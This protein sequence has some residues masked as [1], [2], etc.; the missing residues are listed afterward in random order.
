MDAAHLSRR[1]V[2]AIS[3]GEDLPEP[4]GEYLADNQWVFTQ[5]LPGREASLGRWV[6]GKAWAARSRHAG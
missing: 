3:Y 6:R 5:A 4:L 2:E 1:P